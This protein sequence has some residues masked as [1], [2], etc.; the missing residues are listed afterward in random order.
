M[1]SLWWTALFVYLAG[2]A[3]EFIWLTKIDTPHG[4][5]SSFARDGV[6]LIES[7]LWP[8]ALPLQMLFFIIVTIFDAIL[9]TVIFINETIHE[10]IRRYRG[11]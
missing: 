2:L 3:V 5:T 9:A 10:I 11:H 4:R 6:N 1:D 7:A 8:I